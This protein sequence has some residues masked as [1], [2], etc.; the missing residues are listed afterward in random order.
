MAYG[1]TDSLIKQPDM[2]GVE[3]QVVSGLAKGA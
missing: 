1:I 3:D 2:M